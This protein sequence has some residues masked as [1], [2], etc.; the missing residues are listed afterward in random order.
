[1][2]ATVL[3]AGTLL[4]S[5][6]AAAPPTPDFGPTIEGYAG[7][8]PQDTCDP[9]EKPG[10]Q[11]LRALLNRTYSL[12]RTGNI[13]RQCH[14]GGTSEHKEGRALDYALNVGVASERAIANDILNWML[15]TDRHGNRH[16]IARRMGIMYIIWN[17]QIWSSSRASEGWRPY[18]EPNPHTDHIHWSFS[19]RGARKQT[20]WWTAAPVAGRDSVG[21]FDPRDGTF[22]LRNALDAGGSNYGWEGAPTGPGI[23]PLMGDWDGDGRDSG[24]YFN[25]SD[26]TFHLRNA[27]S[28]GSSNHA[29]DTDITPDLPFIILTG[30]WNG[31]GKDS[32]GYFDPRDG[33][34]HLRN[35]LNPGASDY[36]FEGAPI[37]PDIVPLT[38]DWD[39]N[40][41]D[42]VGYFDRRDGT[43]HL[44]NTLSPGWSN[45]AW[46]TDITPDMPF[47]IL[48]GDWDGDGK[49]SVGYF[50]RADG[51]FHLRNALSPG[52]S[53]Y[54]WDT[55][56]TPDLPFI[57]VTGDWD[58]R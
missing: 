32:V 2:I 46:D 56:I 17:R 11:D 40:G 25:R 57:I 55:N 31:D 16:A 3:L 24:G 42:S 34:F 47:T 33:T 53:N 41:R 52:G 36:A 20:S 49:D 26:G 21:Y 54:A 35:A 15:A 44:R 43:F 12:S 37:G 38:G 10:P 45:Y 58:G 8:D 19:W 14:I 50:N 30:D 4:A 39:G 51:T 29:W 6:T 48:K 5:P 9:T 23:V 7:H 18:T 13:T 1:M 22:H 27:L 28:S